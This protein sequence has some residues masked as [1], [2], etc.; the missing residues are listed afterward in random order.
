MK[1]ST[2]MIKR[3]NDL[4]DDF[5]RKLLKAGSLENGLLKAPILKMLVQLKQ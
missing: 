3:I 1:H 2:Y 4:R 5:Q